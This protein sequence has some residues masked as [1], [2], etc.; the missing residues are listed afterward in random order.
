MREGYV[1][2][3][4][5]SF[6][7]G[8]AW[9]QIKKDRNLSLIAGGGVAVIVGLFLPWFTIDVFTISTS[10]SPGLNGTGLSL[11]VLSVA[12]M[13]ASLNVLKHNK[14]NAAIVAVVVAVL[15]LLVMFNNW[16][17]SSL[18]GT[19]STGIGYWLG[20]LGSVAMVAG[21]GIRLKEATDKKK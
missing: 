7:V 13:A 4:N 20:L 9:E 5:K 11:L 2:S 1:M 18:H 19:V 6:D 15:A 16:P 8:K 17:D 21:S 3:E 12:A 10:T 14:K